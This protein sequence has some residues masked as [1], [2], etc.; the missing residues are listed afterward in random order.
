AR[1]FGAGVADL[2]FDGAVVLEAEQAHQGRE[3]TALKDERDEHY[4]EGREENEVAPREA[5]RERKP[6]GERHD[7]A[8]PA[9]ADGD[10][11]AKGIAR[12]GSWVSLM[13]ARPTLRER[14]GQGPQHPYDDHDRAHCCRR[15]E[16]T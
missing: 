6:R 3:R 4:A 9:P 13:P 1:R 11:G 2:A 7:A 10:A 16:I 14:I 5:A 15:G 12:T 8:H